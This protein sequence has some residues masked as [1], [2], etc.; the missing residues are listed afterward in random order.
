M[1]SRK[2]AVERERE[3]AAARGEDVPGHGGLRGREEARE[4]RERPRATPVALADGWTIAGP[5]D[6]AVRWRT[7]GN[8]IP[9]SSK[10]ARRCRKTGSKTDGLLHV[11]HGKGTEASAQL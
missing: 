8:P 1:L 5:K 7:G 4:R 3:A 10:T 11:T 6:G 2:E 9:G